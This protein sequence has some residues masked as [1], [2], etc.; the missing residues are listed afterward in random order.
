MAQQ[1]RY[2]AGASVT[3]S[4][5]G[6]NGDPAP[7]SSIQV[8]GVDQNGDLQPLSTDTNGVLNVNLVSTDPDPFEVDV[9]HS[10]LPDGAATEATSLAISGKLPATLG[11]K[12]GANSLAVILASDQTLPLPA[13]AST[14]A[15]QTA[16]NASLS[17]LA[18]RTAGSLTPI[19]FDEVDLTYVVAG[20]GIGQIA[21][22]VYKLATA[23]VKTLTFSY[24]GSDRLSSVVA[25]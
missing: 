23:T 5:I 14:S 25:S 15:L 2:P 1:Y 9:I 12:T 6:D 4:A 3:I 17:A 19:A 18:A 11:Q 16:G 22:A 20:N 24:D 10:V 8:G 7:D 21:T 13:G